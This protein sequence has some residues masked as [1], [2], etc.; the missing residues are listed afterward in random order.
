[1]FGSR[2]LNI[3]YSRGQRVLGG[4]IGTSAA[5]VDWILP[6]VDE[7]CAAV[8]ILENIAKR[9]PQTAYYGLAVS[10]QN[11]WQHICRTVPHVGE[12]MGPLEEALC[13][14]L[15]TLLDVQLGEDGELRRLLSHK[16]KQ[17]GM[18]ILIP[19]ES[20][21]VA[22]ATS[23]AASE[24]LV[25]ALR[26]GL[27]LDIEEHQRTVQRARKKAIK[28]RVRKESEECDRQVENADK[29]EENIPKTRTYGT[30]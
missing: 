30:G 5:T 14:F 8:K 10:L 20:A 17:A 22:F 27:D 6:K 1:M 9:Y 15:S 12:L 25:N 16:V 18:G 11:E 23:T 13:S 29:R 3:Q 19:T 21:E 26:Q 4:F 28:E 24:M 7:W 2:G